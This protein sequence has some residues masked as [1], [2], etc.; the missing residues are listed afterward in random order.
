MEFSAAED[1][2][3]GRQASLAT[4][5]DYSDGL[6]MKLGRHLARLKG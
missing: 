5:I 3:G 6:R 2:T 4:A 1:A